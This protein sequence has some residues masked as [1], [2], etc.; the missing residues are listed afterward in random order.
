MQNVKNQTNIVSF[1]TSLVQGEKYG[2][3][4]KTKLNNNSLIV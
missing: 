2:N 3:P 4:L 1:S